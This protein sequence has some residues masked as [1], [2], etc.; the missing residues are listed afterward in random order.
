MS[1]KRKASPALVT[2]SC[3][4]TRAEA[5]F[6]KDFAASRAVFGGGWIRLADVLRRACELAIADRDQGFEVSV[7][8]D[9]DRRA[10]P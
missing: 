4:L 7:V 6:L 8:V 9:N 5:E 1:D 2:R 3:S 10:R